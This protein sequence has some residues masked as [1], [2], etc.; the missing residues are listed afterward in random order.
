MIHHGWIELSGY[1]AGWQMISRRGVFVW[2]FCVRLLA[3]KRKLNFMWPRGKKDTLRKQKGKL[4]KRWRNAKKSKEYSTCLTSN[5]FFPWANLASVFI[6]QTVL[7]RVANKMLTWVPRLNARNSCGINQLVCKFEEQFALRTL[8]RVLRSVQVQCW[9]SLKLF[10]QWH[11]LG[12]L[13]W[14]LPAA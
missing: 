3:W 4:S 13:V 14:L 5:L 9:C 1:L 2:S 11:F 7:D 6:P 8:T 10:T 12:V